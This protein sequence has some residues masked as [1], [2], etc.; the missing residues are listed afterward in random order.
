MCPHLLNSDNLRLKLSLESFKT[1]SRIY[2]FL[3]HISWL[4]L[5]FL[6]CS[7]ISFMANEIFVSLRCSPSI[8]HFKFGDHNHIGSL[9]RLRDLLHKPSQATPYL[10]TNHPL[11]LFVAARTYHRWWHFHLGINPQNASYGSAALLQITGTL[12]TESRSWVS[13]HSHSCCCNMTNMAS[14]CDDLSWNLN[15]VLSRTRWLCV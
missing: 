13:W 12:G 6:S 14:P 1:T 3:F 2:F 9:T 15:V 8:G 7:S 5:S 11:I 4:I 10:V